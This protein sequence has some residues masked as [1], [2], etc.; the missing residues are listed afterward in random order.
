M[1][2][3]HLINNECANKNGIT[4]SNTTDK[5]LAMFIE[6]CKKHVNAKSYDGLIS[7]SNYLDIKSLLDLTLMTAAGNIK[8]NTLAEIHKI[9]NI[10]NDYTT[11]EEEEV[12]YILN[13]SQGSV[14][15]LVGER[16]ERQWAKH[17]GPAKRET[18]HS[19]PKP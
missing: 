16:L 19:Y 13:L 5:I 18:P 2:I 12:F 7:T 11:G 4:I 10:K 15:N 3:K 9:F 6:Y 8:D 17:L 14:M 1:T